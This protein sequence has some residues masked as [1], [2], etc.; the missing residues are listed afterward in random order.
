[1]ENKKVALLLNGDYKDE[2][3]YKETLKDYDFIVCADG[4]GN[5]LYKWKIAPDIIIGDLDSITDKALNYFESINVKVEKFSPEKDYTDSQ[6]GLL[7][8]KELGYKTVDIF[9]G[10]GNRVD[11]SLGNI[12]LIYWGNKEEIEVRLIDENNCLAA[13]KVGKIQISKKENA[14]FSILAHFENLEGLS[15]ENAKY[16]LNNFFLAKG[17]PRGVSNE[18]LDDAVVITLKKGFGLLCV[19]NKI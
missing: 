17:E 16:T 2:E 13:L 3:F 19:S 7:K 4:A 15:I 14:V 6:L 10:F 8:I 11:H 1:M 9:G 18:F 5:I 12:G